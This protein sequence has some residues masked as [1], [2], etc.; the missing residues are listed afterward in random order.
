MILLFSLIIIACGGSKIANNSE[1]LSSRE[2]VTNE[3]TRLSGSV[4]QCN[5]FH[6]PSKSMSGL[7][8]TYVIPST[9]AFDYSRIPLRLVHVPSK[10]LTSVNYKLEMYLWGQN[11]GATARTRQTPVEFHIQNRYT[12]QFILNEDTSLPRVYTSMGLSLINDVVTDYD[13]ENYTINNFFQ[14]HQLLLVDVLV[15]YDAVVLALYPSTGGTAIDYVNFLLP[16]FYSDPNIYANSHDSLTLQEIHPNYPD[17]FNGFTE[18]IYQQNT[19][20]FCKDILRENSLLYA[21]VNVN[22]GR[23]IASVNN[24]AKPNVSFTLMLSKWMYSMRRFLNNLIG[25][26]VFSVPVSSN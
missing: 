11:N 9:G 26:K 24:Q 1:D 15:E 3:D 5:G 12:G 10:I 22:K 2:E 25:L 8:T 17:I 18:E 16:P 19:E 21:Q 7:L 14:K 4:A 23:F 20:E 6:Y 13:D